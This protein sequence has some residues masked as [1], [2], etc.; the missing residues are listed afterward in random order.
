MIMERN[1]GYKV[2]FAGGAMTINY[3]LVATF[4][5]L[6]VSLGLSSLIL[7]CRQTTVS[8]TKMHFVI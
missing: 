6:Q 1:S 4:V 2:H 8:P 5:E 3:Y 7:L